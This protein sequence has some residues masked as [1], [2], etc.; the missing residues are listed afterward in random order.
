MLKHSFVMIQN[1][2]LK[3]CQRNIP[4]FQTRGQPIKFQMMQLLFIVAHTTFCS[5]NKYFQ[6][7]TKMPSFVYYFKEVYLVFQAFTEILVNL[8]TL[9]L[10]RLT[11]KV[12]QLP[13]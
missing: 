9:L 2:I 5:T 6:Q 4:C 7:S 13:F 11:L 3:L 1:L 12:L 8:S 10:V